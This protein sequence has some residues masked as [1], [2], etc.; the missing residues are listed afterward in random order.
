MGDILLTVSQ[1]GSLRLLDHLQVALVI[2]TPSL[3][4]E[5]WASLA[6]N[7]L[8]HQEDLPLNS[9]ALLH[10]VGT[11]TVVRTEAALVE[12]VVGEQERR[13]RRNER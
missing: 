13:R 1:A 10:P 4:V 3:L 2:H 8:A 9:L 7:H 11:A 5:A 6:R 12:V